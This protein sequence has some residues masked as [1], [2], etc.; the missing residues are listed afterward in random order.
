MKFNYLNVLVREWEETLFNLTVYFIYFVRKKFK[1]KLFIFGTIFFAPITVTLWT[2]IMVHIVPLVTVDNG[3]ICTI[4]Y[5]NIFCS[6]HCTAKILKYTNFKL[7]IYL[8]YNKMVWAL[9][10]FSYSLSNFSKNN[11][12]HWLQTESFF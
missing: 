4:F 12:K 8:C 3:T 2:I 6:Y 11:R 1:S 7:K 5:N 10:L 9:Q